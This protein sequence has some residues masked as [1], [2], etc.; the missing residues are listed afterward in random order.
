M[1][2]VEEVDSDE[3]EHEDRK[4]RP[5]IKLAPQGVVGTHPVQGLVKICPRPLPQ[6]S[7]DPFLQTRPTRRALQMSASRLI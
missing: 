7:V 5:L 4:T 1:A 2:G 3:E 6:A